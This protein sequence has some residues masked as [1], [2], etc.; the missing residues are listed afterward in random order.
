MRLKKKII[1][2]I[3]WIG[4][5]IPSNHLKEWLAASPAAMKWQK[6][7]YQSLVEETMD[8]EWIYYRPDSY[9]PKGRL[10]PSTVNISSKHVKNF[11]QIHYLNT[12]G[13]RNITLKRSLQNI[14]KEK[15][16]NNNSQPL[17]IVSY[18]GPKWMK[19]IF[20]DENI[21]KNFHCIYIVA[22]EEVPPGAD[23]YVFLSY[24]S[25]KKY[26]KKQIKL[27]LDGAVYP[28]L[29]VPN[30]QK[31]CNKK[32]IF[33][34][35]GSFFKYTGIK[36]LL[37]ATEL[38]K[39]NNFEL[40]ISGSGDDKFL[41]LAMKKD[42]RIK[43]FG[44][45]TN[46]Q[47]QKTYNK[48]NVFLNPRPVNMALNNISFPSK[49]FDYLSWNKPIISTCT[50]SLDPIYKKILHIVDDDPVSIAIAMRDYLDGKKYFKTK[51]KWIVDKNW[52]NEGKKFKNFLEKIIK[53]NRN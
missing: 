38:L 53:K 7:L 16:K 46:S 37:E 35:S 31:V 23:G 26:K 2:K 19:K 33:F 22:D 48:A 21:R 29:Q 41:K 49:L 39:E 42:K 45:L 6:H 8:I 18:N 10:L 20:S 51:K 5:Y 32:T 25:F 34:Y 27:H 1:P 36:I 43:F 12:I 24:D 15:V 30:S 52:R 9:W 13:L 50:K 17:I 11:S 14:L 4:P 28:S 3:L 47:L 44:L 40:W